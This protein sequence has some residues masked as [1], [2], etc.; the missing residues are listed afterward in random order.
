MLI[1][2]ATGKIT[3]MSKAVHAMAVG[4]GTYVYFAERSSDDNLGIIARAAVGKAGSQPTF[5]AGKTGIGGTPNNGIVGFGASA[6]ITPDGKQIFIAGMEDV[7]RTERLQIYRAGKF[8]PLADASEKPAFLRASDITAS[9][10]IVAF[11]VGADNQT[12][13]GYI[14]LK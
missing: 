9:D 6:A 1:D 13:V 3:E 11:K 4:G 14:K 2:A 8:V 7:G 5:S 10:S 12:T